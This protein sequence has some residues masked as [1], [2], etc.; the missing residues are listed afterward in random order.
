MKVHITWRVVTESL[1]RDTT[2][3]VPQRHNALLASQSRASR[4][5]G[6]GP[7]SPTTGRNVQSQ[8]ECPRT[9]SPSSLNER[10]R[11]ESQEEAPA[12]K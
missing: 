9:K 3:A 10:H 8:D 7:S 2:H 6:K 1:R 5:E 12:G 4:Q 11:P